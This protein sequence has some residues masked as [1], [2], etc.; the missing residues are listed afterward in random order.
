MTT[1]T[2]SP[3]RLRNATID[4]LATIQQWDQQPHLQDENVMG[5][6][7]YNDW[8][9]SVELTKQ[10]SWR[11]QLIVELEN[12]GP[13]G[14]LQIID[15]AEEESHYWGDDC[16]R[17]L[18]A[19]D[20]WIGEPEYIGQGHGTQIMKLALAE[21]CFSNPNVTAILVD[22]MANNLRAHKFYQKLGF[23]PQE[24][25]YFGPDRTLVHRLTRER[26]ERKQSE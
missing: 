4:D 16:P 18:R 5:D 10:P 15:P 9:W 22:P 17:N 12:A 2:N 3:V 8:N 21:Y 23:E 1:S 19:M 7:A 13:I 25:R 20:I 11:Y 14:M 6:N 24:I 26:Y